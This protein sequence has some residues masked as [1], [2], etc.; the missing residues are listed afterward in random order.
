MITGIDAL[1][2]L[3][4]REKISAMSPLTKTGTDLK[5]NQNTAANLLACSREE[6][7]YFLPATTDLSFHVSD[8]THASL[9]ANAPAD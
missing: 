3:A 2:S 8:S 6:S 4:T 7:F 5:Y 9:P 1:S